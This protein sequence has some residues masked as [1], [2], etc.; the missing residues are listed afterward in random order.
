L[1]KLVFGLF[2]PLCFSQTF[3]A[4]RWVQQLDN[5]GVDSFTGLGTD[6]QGNIYVAGGTLSASFPVKSAVQNNLASAGLYRID[7]PGSAY[8]RLS[9]NRVLTNLA[10]DPVNPNVFYAVSSGSG[11]KSVDG[12]NT[13]TALTIPSQQIQQ[14]AVD[15]QNDQTIYVAAFD[16]GVLKSTDGGATWN[17]VNNGITPCTRCNLSPGYFGARSIWIDPNSSAVFVYVG[18]SLVRTGDGGASW[19]TVSPSDNGFAVYFETPKP[20]VVYAFLFQNGPMKSTDGGQTFQRVSIP[21]TS[22]FADPNQPNRLLGTGSGGIFESTDDGVTWTQRLSIQGAGI[23]AADW[24]NG[25]LYAAAVTSGIVQISSDLKTVTPVGPAGAVAKGLVLASGHVYVPN[26]GGHNSFVS[27]LDPSGNVV[28]S[29]YFGGS[30]DDNP[31]AMAVDAA[32]NV[33]V[34]GTSTSLDFPTSKGAYSTSPGS[35]FLFKLK[36]D[37]SVGYSTYFPAGRTTPAGI[38]VDAAGSAYLAGPTN[39]GLPTTAGAYQTVC[40]CTTIST[41]FSAGPKPDLTIAYTDTF[42]TKFDPSAASLTYSTYLGVSNVAL[43]ASVGKAFTLGP[44]GSAYV[45][46]NS[47][48]RINATGSSLLATGAPAIGIEAMAVGPDGSVYIAGSANGSR[49]QPTSGAF[50]TVAPPPAL[51]YQNGGASGIVKMDSQLQTIL[52][53]T[54]FGGNY[55]PSISALILDP[56]GN[57]YVGGG[58]QPRGVPT[59][60][61]LFGAFG[62]ASGFL[63][64][65]SSDLSTLLFSTYLGDTESFGVGGIALGSGGTVIAGGATG[66]PKNIWVNSLQPAAPPGLRI[67]SINNAASVLDGPLSAGETILILGA[68]FG[69]DSQIIIGGAAVP[70]LSISPTQITAVVPTNLPVAPVFVQVQSGGATSNQVLLPI[71]TASPGIFSVDGTGSGQGY[72]LNQDGTLNSLSNPARIGDKI[73]IYATGV[74]PVS[75]NGPYAVTGNPV[76]VFVDVFFADGVAAV[77][78]PVAGFPGSVYQVTVYVPNPAAINPDLKN[79]TYPPQVGITM[80]VAGRTS[81]NGLSIAIAP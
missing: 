29:T 34:T 8:T 31:T 30:G 11:V 21:V 69:A 72:I 20:G 36:P 74:G 57:V 64:E 22:I 50:Q 25:F 81:Q 60:T 47:V 2:I 39:G 51:P 10:A 26:S 75:F 46:S 23:V 49:F 33:Y 16:I 6:A 19:Q 9:L 35:I 55:N 54:Y 18:I 78:G 28:Y 7:G 4:L 65:L 1:L 42:I 15:P 79:F 58:S 24:A 59:R 56:A 71:A 61:P 48:Y 27:K 32:G 77:M 40:G 66:G 73:T 13:W 80:Q 3:P 62:P 63:S 53:A 70:A 52:A 67:D 14:F 76:N 44:D 43:S 5:S 68:G 17:L 37:G 45:G 38:A 41:G 12:G